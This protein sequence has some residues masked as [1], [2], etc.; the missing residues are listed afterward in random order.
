[1]TYEN[2]PFIEVDF[3]QSG[4]HGETARGDV[5]VSRKLE[6]EDRIVCVMADGLGSGV[7][8]N[9]LAKMTS[10][11]AMNFVCSDMDL[12]RTADIIMSTLPVCSR[13]KIAYATFTIFDITDNGDVRVI[14]YDNPEYVILRG[15]KPVE[16][17]KE[18]LKVN[19]RDLGQR[20]LY[21][22]RFKAEHN[23][24]A[25]IF[26]DGITQS[27]MGS[28]EYPLGWG[29]ENAVK[30]LTDLCSRFPEISARELSGS[31]VK[32]ALTNDGLQAKDD[33]TCGVINFR[34]PRRLLAVTGPPMD[35]RKDVEISEKVKDFKGS[36]VICGGTT[37]NIIAR[38]LGREVKVNLGELDSQLPPV[39]AMEGVDLITEGTLTLNKTAELLEKGVDTESMK[40][41]SAVKLADMFINSDIIDFIVGTRVNNAHQD[42]NLPVELDIRRNLVKRIT[43]ALKERYLKQVNMRFV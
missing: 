20:K 37:A 27:G 8:A 9:V 39:S 15:G 29:R 32:K 1:M 33:I 22:S 2:K 13:R 5:F 4:K 40:P 35:E 6:Q 24:R 25:V 41:N 42:P 3:Q 21:Y 17:E 7:K 36:K 23:T 12:H 19:T 11:M 26:S 18:Q 30:L 31:M 28:D 38:E 34:K 10:T 16:I 43:A 14:E